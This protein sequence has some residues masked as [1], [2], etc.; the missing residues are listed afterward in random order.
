MLLRKFTIGEVNYFCND[1]QIK[2]AGSLEAAAQKMAGFEMGNHKK[3][4]PEV[5]KPEGEK[6]NEK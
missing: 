6:P 2:E 3:P 1:L 4:I 5:K